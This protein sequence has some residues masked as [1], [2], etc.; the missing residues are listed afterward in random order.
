M[1]ERLIIIMFF[2]SPAIILA[3]E[4]RFAGIPSDDV[5][6]DYMTDAKEYAAL[7]LGKVEI[8]YDKR[9]TN[10]PYFETNMFQSG[11]LG[12]NHV[13]YKDVMMRFDLFRNEL[14]VFSSDKPY[15]I[16]LNNEK[17]DFAILNGSTILLL[18]NKKESSKQFLVLLQNG[19]YPVLKK[20]IMDVSDEISGMQV[21]NYFRIKSQYVIYKD[22]IPYSVK[23]K[24]S[25]LKLFPDKRKELDA[26]AKQH[27][28]DFKR[29]IDQSIIALVNHY[30]NLTNQ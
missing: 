3:Q 12:Y 16:V 26:F 17:F 5:I 21:I 8:P 23:N 30:E 24:N 15:Y 10:H 19:K 7:F 4:N 1:K 22:G 18:D 28:L 11:T 14:T 20:F 2:L 29:Q 9:F 6:R 13:V 27:K 25:I